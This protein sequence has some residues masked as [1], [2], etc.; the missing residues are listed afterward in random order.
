MYF[1]YG[2]HVHVNTC[3]K[4]LKI[5]EFYINFYIRALIL[6]T[7]MLIFKTNKHVYIPLICARGA[8]PGK[9]TPASRRERGKSNIYD[10]MA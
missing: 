9:R 3:Y 1:V 8:W 2:L 7:H 5:C 10:M 6:N 4:F